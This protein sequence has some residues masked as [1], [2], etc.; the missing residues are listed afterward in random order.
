MGDT[1]MLEEVLTRRFSHSAD[2]QP[3]DKKADKKISSRAKEEKWPLPDLVILDGGKGQLSVALK[4]LKKYKLEIPLFA[5]SKGEG[6]RSALAPDKLFF[7]GQKKPLE[8]PL[9]S[10]ALHIAKRVRDESHR[11]AV[12]YHQELRK[13]KFYE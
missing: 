7:P 9:S 8:L 1:G 12:K 11:F 5:I 6:L 2:N 3:P 13:K 4:V 10:P